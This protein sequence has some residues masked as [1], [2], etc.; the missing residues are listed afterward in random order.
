MHRCFKILI[1]MAV[2]IFLTP[3]F[4]FAQV[5]PE[6]RVFDNNGYLE[7]TVKILDESYSGAISFAVGDVWAGEAKEIVVCLGAGIQTKVIIYSAEGVEL[8]AFMPFAENFQGGCQVSLGDVDGDMKDEIIVSAGF[9][10]GP[11]VKI[12]EGRYEQRNFFAF[13]KD[14]RNGV[15]AVSADLG[16]DSKAEIIAFSNYNQIPEY[17]VFGNDGNKLGD[18]KLD[19]WNNNGISLAV[20]DFNGDRDKEFTYIGGYGNKPEIVIAG[21]YNKFIRIIP[22]VDTAAEKTLNLASGDLNNDGKDEIVVAEGYGGVGKIT[23]Y[24]YEGEIIKSFKI[25]ESF[26]GGL[27]VAVS[28]IDNDGSQEIIVLPERLGEDLKS[29]VYKFITVDLTQQT[30]YRY[31]DGK[32]LNTFLISSGKSKTPT[33]VGE[34]SIFRKRDRVWMSGLNYSLPNVPWVASYDGAYT[35]HGTYWHNN[36]GHPM[37][38]GCINMRTSEAKVVYDWSEIGTPVIIF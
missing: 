11:Q 21:K 3:L 10:G 26:T 28:D 9:S 38:H 37:S 27:N 18:Y 23:V 8:E 12:F 24:N 5:L 32:L 14:N 36:F 22:Y 29:S 1:V 17:A 33:R 4:V 31:Q 20:G 34:F 2:G 6:V 13:N 19:N 7:K 30:L 35:I 15:R 25:T 16:T